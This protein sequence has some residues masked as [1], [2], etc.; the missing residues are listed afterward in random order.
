M[1]VSQSWVRVVAGCAAGLVVLA[2]CGSSS[3]PAANGTST[4]ATTAPAGSST[5]PTT[6][7]PESGACPGQLVA[8]IRTDRPSY[9]GGS[10]VR[11]TVRMR[12]VSDR[13]CVIRDPLPTPF[14]RAFTVVDRRGAIVWSP[15]QRFAGLGVRPQPVTLAPGRDYGYATGTWD[16]RYCTGACAAQFGAGTGSEGS[17][18]PAGTYVIRTTAATPNGRIAAADVVVR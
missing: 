4:T 12:N 16:L 9:S 14:Q 10:T 6:V 1:T 8:D 18:V 2:G 17:A 13:A 3:T 5:V 15:G 11:V 7:V